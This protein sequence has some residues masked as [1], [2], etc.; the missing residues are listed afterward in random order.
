MSSPVDPVESATD[1]DVALLG[2]VEVRAAH[3]FRRGA[4]RDLVVYLACHPRG[5]RT[6]QWVQA[7]WPDRAVSPSTVHSTASDAR[8]A[9][10]PDRWGQ[11]RMAR[12]G[13]LLR[14]AECVATD[15]DRFAHLAGSDAPDAALRALRLVRGIPL[16][17]LSRSDWAVFDGTQA[18]LE[19]MVVELALGACVR[20]VADGDATGAEQVVRQGLLASPYDERLYRALLRVT[21]A[22]GD[23]ARLPT[24]MARLRV[25]A[26]DDGS[27][28]GE[29][30]SAR[31]ADR[32][33]P[34]TTALY[35][36]LLHG[37]PAVGGHPAR[38]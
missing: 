29:G 5:V 22:Q 3:S 16:S 2:P 28:P 9:L 35:Q 6:A 19:A 14:L 31:F 27:V 18:R 26:G 34:E 8:R 24:T 1:L 38:L 23:R 11:P 15:V 13:G 32:L 36:R 17:G 30:P 37:L 12:Q 33:H 25:L 4:A 21:V 10:G 20:L 7:L